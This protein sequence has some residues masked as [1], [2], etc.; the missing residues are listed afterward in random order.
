MA[1]DP[2]FDMT[3]SRLGTNAVAGPEEMLAANADRE[4]AIDVLRAGFAEGRLTK[5]EYDDRTAR[6]Y[7]ARTYGQLAALTADLPPGPFGLPVRYPGAGYPPL[8]QARSGVNAMAVAALACGIGE[9]LTMG[10]TAIPAIILGHAARRQMR[11]TGEQGDGMALAG[12][13]LGWIGLITA[14][15][16]GLILATSVAR[17]G[18]VHTI[19]VIPQGPN[20]PNGP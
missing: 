17:Q 19:V 6:V 13:T 8:Q 15:I 4:R 1:V 10:L 5:D 11:R 12:L 7:A 14:I 9:F 2:A 3:P 18:V 20:G 16:A